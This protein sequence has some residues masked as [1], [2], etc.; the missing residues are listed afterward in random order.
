[1]M[2]A[3]LTRKEFEA[4]MDEPKQQV[5]L[6]SVLFP[7][8][9]LLFP[10]GF[11]VGYRSSTSSSRISEDDKSFNLTM[12]VPGVAAEGVRLQVN[13]DGLLTLD[14]TNV[15]GQHVIDRSLQL[16]HDA[17]LNSIQAWCADGILE[18]TANKLQP[19]PPTN[20]AV[21]S[22]APPALE[23]EGHSY[24][25]RRGVPGLSAEEVTITVEENNILRIHA[26]SIRGYGERHLDVALPEDALAQHASA[27]C[28]HGVL[29]VRVPYPAPVQP[30]Q[31][32]VEESTKLP[33]DAQLLA[34][35]RVP[36]IGAGDVKLQAT[37]EHVQLRLEKDGRVVTRQFSLPSEVSDPACLQA[38][39]AN[40]LLQLG[41][42]KPTIEEPKEILVQAERPAIRASEA[43]SALASVE[44]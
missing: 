18:I 2:R 11:R 38:V 13:N 27:F 31:V 21:Q 20:I 10:S 26:S 24:E 22:E 35:L 23:D 36:G 32:A 16:S 33:E 6:A 1:M 4:M 39:C 19:D 12:Q 14:V 44:E 3:M 9:S 30:T 17:D 34:K 41:F 5:S 7:E 40:G 8:R 28:Q 29:T 15:D 25:V 43:E 37:A 42:P